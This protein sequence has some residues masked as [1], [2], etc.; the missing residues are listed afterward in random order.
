MQD[1]EQNQELEGQQVQMKNFDEEVLKGLRVDPNFEEP[2]L[3]QVLRIAVYDEYHAYE[4]YKKVIEKFGEVPPFSNVLEAEIKHFQELAMLMEKHQVALPIN[5]FE[6]KIDAPDSLLEAAEIAVAAEIDNIKMYDNLIN[7]AKTYPDVLD[8]LY[9]LQAA[10]YNNHLPAFRKEVAK[11]S[12]DTNV[13]INQIHQQYSQH[14]IDEAM[15]K[16]DE[17]SQMASKFATG[18]VSQEDIMKLLGN[19]NLSFIG[20]ALIGAIGAGVVS[21][22]VKDKEEKNINEEV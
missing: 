8:T 3:H 1:S 2:V 19:T 18:E 5:D 11:Y 12:N 4:T 16:M 14:N 22:V 17:F 15:S 9:R 13:N 6:G 21:Q 7:Y 20:G 10:S